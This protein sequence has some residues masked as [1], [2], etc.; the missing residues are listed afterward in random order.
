MIPESK[1]KLKLE[2]FPTQQMFCFRK[3][4]LINVAVVEGH[5]NRSKRIPEK[6]TK[7]RRQYKYD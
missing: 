4:P 2:L 7:Y 5:Q 6:Q 3:F 1:K